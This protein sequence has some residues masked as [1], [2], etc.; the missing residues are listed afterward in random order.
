MKKA[1]IF[2]MDGVIV[3]SEGLWARAEKEVF[4]S[5]GVAMDEA[6]CQQTKSMTT[7]E[8]TAFWYARSPWQGKAMDEVEQMVV[9][10]VIELIEKENCEIDGIVELVKQLKSLGLKIGLATN[11][12]YQIVPKVLSKLALSSL[13]DCTV[14]AEFEKQGKPHPDVYLTASRQL[15][16]NAKN[17]IAIEDSKSGIRAAKR[18]GITVIGFTNKGR[19]GHL[20]EADGQIE[21]FTNIDWEIFRR[22]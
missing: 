9:D 18:A 10:R 21:D 14:S 8:V 5:L 4:S 2:D 13:F 16:E 1:V 11:A 7:A 15:G 19:N 22:Q 3:D 6:S 20:E 17:C 12:P